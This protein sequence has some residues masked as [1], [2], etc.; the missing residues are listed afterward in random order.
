[1]RPPRLRLHAATPRVGTSSPRSVNRRHTIDKTSMH[2][3]RIAAATTELPRNIHTRVGGLLYDLVEFY[4]VH[5]GSWK[6]IFI[7]SPTTQP[8][9]YC[10][11][12]RQFAQ[13]RHRVG[14]GSLT[15]RHSWLWHNSSLS[16]RTIRSSSLL[17]AF[18][19]LAAIF[20]LHFHV[21]CCVTFRYIIYYIILVIYSAP[22]TKWT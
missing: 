9:D 2:E 16:R 15:W 22:I 7:V 10:S 5:C 20:Y 1:M 4:R 18:L 11:L 8:A 3:H 6:H 12:H 14:M 13:C 21:L 17:L 19:R